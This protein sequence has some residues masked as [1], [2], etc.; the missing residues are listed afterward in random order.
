MDAKIELVHSGQT[1]TRT[2]CLI[3]CLGL[4]ASCRRD[5]GSPAAQ[6]PAPYKSDIESLC[7]SVVRSGADQLTPGNRPLAIATWLGQHLQTEEAHQYLVKIQ[8]LD[9]DAKAH[10]LDAEALRVGLPG[11]ALSAEWRTSAAKP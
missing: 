1:M 2:A 10:A 3:A 6:V 7:D 4:A 8:P 5:S 11:C 9:G